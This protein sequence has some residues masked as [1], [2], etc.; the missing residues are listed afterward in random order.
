MLYKCEVH[1]D[2]RQLHVVGLGLNCGEE[3]LQGGLRLGTAPQAFCRLHT[4]TDLHFGLSPIAKRGGKG[5]EEK[6]HPARW[7]GWSQPSTFSLPLRFDF[8]EMA[9][10]KGIGKA[11]RV[12][13]C[14]PG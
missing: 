6:R 12:R 2:V 3:D 7:R 9:V 5:G 8:G 1:V 4:T 13:V 10:G 11:C 14:V